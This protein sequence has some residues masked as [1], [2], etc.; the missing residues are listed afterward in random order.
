MSLKHAIY[1]DEMRKR[2]NKRKEQERMNKKQNA[3]ML[4]NGQRRQ[5]VGC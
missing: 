1:M 3:K 2:D 4:R 5:R